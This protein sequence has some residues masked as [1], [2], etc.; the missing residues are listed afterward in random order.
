[1]LTKSSKEQIFVDA[2]K[3]DFDF[4]F[5]LFSQSHKPIKLNILNTIYIY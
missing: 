3:N 2:L 4:H 5:V 1:M